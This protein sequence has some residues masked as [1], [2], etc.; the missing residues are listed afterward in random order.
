MKK[1][2][3]LMMIVL[4]A[5]SYGRDFEYNERRNVEMESSE[6]VERVGRFAC[7][8]WDFDG[9]S[10]THFHRELETQYRGHEGR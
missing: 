1:I 5:I 10:Y 2:L 6:K 7:D 8:I 9:R 3:L 4:G